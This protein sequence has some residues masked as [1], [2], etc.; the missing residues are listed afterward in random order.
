MRTVL[1]SSPSTAP[2]LDM[3][4]LRMVTMVSSPLWPS[5]PTPNWSGG[6]LSFSSTPGSSSQVVGAFTPAL[7]SRVA[8]K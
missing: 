4:K 1:P 8:L 6:L 2:P 5:N 7:S 3:M